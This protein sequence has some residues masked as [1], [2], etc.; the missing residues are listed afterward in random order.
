MA[1]SSQHR[2]LTAAEERALL[3]RA[4]AGDQAAREK[5]VSHNERLIWREVRR[6]L[7]WAGTLERDDLFLEGVTGLL[8]AIDLFD[9][10]RGTRLST[11][12]TQWIRQAIGRAIQADSRLIRLPSHVWDRL[13]AAGQGLQERGELETAAVAEA[14][15]IAPA[16]VEIP[17]SID[18]PI[19]EGGSLAVEAIPAEGDFTEALLTRLDLASLLARLSPRERQVI[20]Q[21]YGLDGL[22][23]RTL[24]AV[25]SELGS[26]CREAIR[27]I[28][29]RALRKL[30]AMM[31]EGGWEIPPGCE[32]EPA[33]AAPAERRPKPRRVYEGER[34]EVPAGWLEEESS[35][36]MLLEV[37]G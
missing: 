7:Q 11:Y 30:R 10:D 2:L 23:V 3:V 25:G 32:L 27:Q 18:V 13:R 20:I 16:A 5:L 8:R 28:E 33:P 35:R 14:A 6:Y 26:L 34:D 15:G 37:S 21:R 22:D 36:P 17:L 4:R 29:A 19:G 1:E 9:L 24:A 31:E 12:A